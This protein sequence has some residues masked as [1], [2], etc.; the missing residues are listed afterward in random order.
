LKGYKVIKSAGTDHI[1]AELIKAGGKTVRCEVRKL[2]ISIWKKEELPEQRKESIILRIYKNYDKTD[3]SNYRG[4]S[5]LLTTYK[6]LSNNL[7]S[8]LTPYAEGIS[9]NRQC[10]FRGSRLTTD[11]I[12]C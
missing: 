8:N 6:T 10:G 9:G 11:H 12:F 5:V 3:Y 7:L 1:P 2:I 4:V